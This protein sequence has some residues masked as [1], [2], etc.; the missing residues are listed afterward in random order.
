MNQMV[1]TWIFG[2][3]SQGEYLQVQDGR[4]ARQADDAAHSLAILEASKL[5]RSQ[6]DFRFLISQGV[7]PQHPV[8]PDTARREAN[9]QYIFW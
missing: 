6:A 8:S 4:K 2:D 7:Q 5:D 9:N 1:F 3:Y